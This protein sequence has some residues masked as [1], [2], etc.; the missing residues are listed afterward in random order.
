MFLYK[1]VLDDPLP[2]LDHITRAKKST[3]LPVVLSQF[4]VAALLKQVS[5]TTGLIVHL[6]YGTGMRLMEALRL[7]VKDI[8]FDAHIIL[9]R[10]GKGDKDRVVPLPASLVQPLRDQLADRLRMHHKDQAL[11]MVDVELPY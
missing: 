2:W 1:E 4:E 3:R 5:G 9:V 7:R 11:G 6:L 10:S 8:D